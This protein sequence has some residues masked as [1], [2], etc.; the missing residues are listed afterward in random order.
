LLISAI[1]AYLVTAEKV[2]RDDKQLM[3]FESSRS[4]AERAA[5]AF[6]GYIRRVRT[7]MEFL[8]NLLLS[9]ESVR[10]SAFTNEYFTRDPDIVLFQIITE[11]TGN[12]K[13]IRE[14][15]SSKRLA[16]TG[17]PETLVRE[18]VTPRQELSVKDL[19]IENRST[20]AHIIYVIRTPM[21]IPGLPAGTAAY[22]QCVVDGSR[23][24]NALTQSSSS[25]G[26]TQTFAITADGDLFAHSD[27]SQFLVRRNMKGMPIV[28]F[29]LSRDFISGQMRFEFEDKSYI[30]VYRKTTSTGLIIVTLTDREVILGAGRL[31]LEKAILLSSIIVTVVF[32]LTLLFANSLSQPILSLVKATKDIA[33]G[34]FNNNIE[35]QSGDEIG[36]LARAFSKMSEQIQDSRT[37]LE[38]YNRRLEKKVLERTQEL[39]LKNVAIREQQDMLLHATKMAAIGEIAGQAAHEVLNPLAAM[40]ARIDGMGTRL[41]QFHEK[42]NAPIPTARAIIKEWRAQF[43]MGGQ[44]AWLEDVLQASR[45]DPKN[46]LLAEDMANLNAAFEQLEAFRNAL[47][48]DLVL[49]S[50]EGKRIG[51]IIDSMRSENHPSQTKREKLDICEAVTLCVRANEDLL[52]QHDIEVQ[53]QFWD[54]PYY[55]RS[56]KDDVAQILSNLVKNSVDA[57]IG[58]RKSRTATELLEAGEIKGQIRISTH[59]DGPWIRIKVW[60]NGGGIP[61]ELRKKIFQT[62]FTTKGSEGTGLGLSISRRLCRDSGGDLILVESEIGHHTEF[63]ITLPR[64]AGT[65]DSSLEAA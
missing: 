22:A 63:H 30:G 40:L 47:S 49:L 50:E 14:M 33:R 26:T 37:Q 16:E 11:R 64:L 41:Q 8:S 51:R 58:W 20:P 52:T 42:V 60:D 56:S 38:D 5:N 34:V 57:I 48:N 55:V 45:V 59:V 15:F 61:L 44:K 28:A 31:L 32:I 53:T 25:R 18:S 21:H 1:F 19:T 43:E 10:N 4:E 46:T 23:W 35:I 54:G 7:K 13:T 3:V 24:L 17:I 29:A 62:R 65:G 2:F 12:R 36:V 39:E 9:S 6:D 27:K